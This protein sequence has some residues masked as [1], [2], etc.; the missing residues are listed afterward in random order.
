MVILGKA[1]GHIPTAFSID[2]HHPARDDVPQNQCNMLHK[3][4]EVRPDVKKTKRRNVIERHKWRLDQLAMEITRAHPRAVKAQENATYFALEVGQKL[5]VAHIIYA[6]LKTKLRKKGQKPSHPTWKAWV[7]AKCGMSVRTSYYYRQLD[8]KEN[9]EIVEA[10]LHRPD[11]SIRKLVRAIGKVAEEDE[12]DDPTRPADERLPDPPEPLEKVCRSCLRESFAEKVR[13]LPDQLAIY[14]AEY[15]DAILEAAWRRVLAEA[16]PM[17]EVLVP[18]FV[19]L[20]EAQ[21]KLNNDGVST[22]E[23]SNQSDKLHAVFVVE[24]I[25]GM[26][27]KSRLS[28]YQKM[29][30]LEALGYEDV[31]RELPSRNELSRQCAT[32]WKLAH[33][34]ERSRS[35]AWEWALTTHVEDLI[36]PEEIEERQRRA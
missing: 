26:R 6:R 27:F 30:V 24:V 34:K 32:I 36:W 28:E 5:N 14:L 20:R 13:E 2:R 1:V 12:A 10:E 29:V 8:R 15:G 31:R 23:F 25:K 22:L 16:Q 7:T 18:A 3:T 4:Q 35:S 21:D 11:V 33:G 19:K 17:V 9:R